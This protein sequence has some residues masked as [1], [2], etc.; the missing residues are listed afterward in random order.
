M[1]FWIEIHCDAVDEDGNENRGHSP[2]CYSFNND[3]L[4]LMIDRSVIP[5][6]LSTLKKNA[7][8]AKWKFTRKKGWICP[9]CAKE[10]ND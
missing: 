9:N 3:S 10:K 1:P 4:G 8:E 5:L 6:G 7:L 2:W